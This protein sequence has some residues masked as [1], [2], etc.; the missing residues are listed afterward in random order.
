[1]NSQV[2]AMTHDKRLFSQDFKIYLEVQFMEELRTL[3]YTVNSFEDSNTK[4]LS[5]LMERNF[6]LS[7]SMSPPESEKNRE[8]DTMG[9]PDGIRRLSSSVS[10]DKMA[11]GLIS[12]PRNNAEGMCLIFD[13][14]CSNWITNRNQTC[15][16]V[17]M[18]PHSRLADNDRV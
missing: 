3:N 5:D 6:K 10:R 15:V 13:K 14:L 12:S 4:Q 1:M 16:T 2:L 9:I 8:K 18:P 7:L 11:A 17:C